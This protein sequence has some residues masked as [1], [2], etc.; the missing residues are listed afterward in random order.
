MMHKKLLP[1][2]LSQVRPLSRKDEQGRRILKVK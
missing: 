2:L 1:I